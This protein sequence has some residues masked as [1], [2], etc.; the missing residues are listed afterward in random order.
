MPTNPPVWHQAA[1]TT[2]QISSAVRELGAVGA[3]SLAAASVVRSGRD[4]AAGE[5]AVDS[6]DRHIDESHRA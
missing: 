4:R 5:I 1:V 3:V 6:A 2:V